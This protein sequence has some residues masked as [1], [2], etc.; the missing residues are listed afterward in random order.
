MARVWI[1]LPDQDFDPTE[2][3]VPWQALSRAGHEV[4]F[5]TESGAAVPKADPRVLQGVLFGKMG[6]PPAGKAAYAEMEQSEAFKNP[7][8][9]GS[10]DV[11]SFDGLVLP[12]G[13]A[14]GM[15]PYLESETLRAQVRAFWKLERPVG[16]ICHGVLVLARTRDFATGKSVI[17][18]RRTTC[19]TKTMELV[20]YYTTFWKLGRYYRT[21]D[22][23]VQDEVK[24]ALVNPVTQF[25]KGPFTLSDPST[26]DLSF[27]KDDPKA[28][29]VQDGR[30]L[31]A[32]WP[33]DAFSFAKSFVALVE[34][35]VAVAAEPAAPQAERS[36]A[37]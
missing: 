36:L 29:V 26:L 25:E 30:Y 15:R 10:L 5:A 37:S 13:H 2:S 19:L 3:A 27:D 20:A 28:F 11:A 1:P 34:G 18:T 32:R 17:A 14:P 35:R 6:A 23:T 24:E 16:A 31:S 7:V 33:G 8:A 21:Y 4:V 22:Q 12:G 9:W